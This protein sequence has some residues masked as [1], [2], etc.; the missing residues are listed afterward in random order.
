MFSLLTVIILVFSSTFS[1]LP[2]NACS[3][4][5][6]GG[7]CACNA[8]DRK[9]APVSAAIRVTNRRGDMSIRSSSQF[10]VLSSDF[11]LLRYGADL[12]QQRAAAVLRHVDDDTI[13]DLDV[14]EM[15]GLAGG[16]EFGLGADRERLAGLV[17]ELDGDRLR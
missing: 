3:F 7:F 15:T 11:L 10:L 9:S 16:L 4:L 2:L 13:A 12:D 1:T 17:R 6:A 8:T 5:S 14:R